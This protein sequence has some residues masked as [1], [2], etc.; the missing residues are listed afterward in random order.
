MFAGVLLEEGVGQQEDVGFPLPEWGDVD[1]EDVEALE[2]VSP[3]APLFDGELE[4]D[5]E[6]TADIRRGVVSLPHGWGHDLPGARLTTAAA[7]AG[8]NSNTLTDCGPIDPLS[9]NAELNGIPV[10]IERAP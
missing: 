3:E 5:V 9:G 1:R 6:P 4:V 2:Q 10:L 8:V 7:H